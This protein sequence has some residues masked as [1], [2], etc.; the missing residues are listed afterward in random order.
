MKE[1]RSHVELK[2][3]PVFD[4][5]MQA[6]E[7]YM[8]YDCTLRERTQNI[9]FLEKIIV[10]G[11]GERASSYNG[12]FG[13]STGHSANLYHQS[14][15]RKFNKSNLAPYAMRHSSVYGSPYIHNK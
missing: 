8:C 2:R 1:A 13:K 6:R 11:I 4:S 10:T 5:Y 12:I 14:R 7:G 9:D 3:R 15:Y